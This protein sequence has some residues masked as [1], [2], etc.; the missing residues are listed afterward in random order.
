MHAAI[1]FACLTTVAAMSC[2]APAFAE[3]SG[4]TPYAG[5]SYGVA[6]PSEGDSVRASGVMIG[7]RTSGAELTYGGELEF[8]KSDSDDF[9]DIA[10]L[11][12]IVHNDLGSIGLFGTMGLA[13]MDDAFG[14]AADGFTYGLGADYEVTERTS[15]RLEMIRDQISDV[16]NST[17][18]RLGV[19]FSF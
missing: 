10:R 13:R 5:L 14:E 19:A 9:G 2:A 11:R 16:P 8:V 12:G 18:M 15:L 3:D 7:A 1:K 6:A 17:T 4:I